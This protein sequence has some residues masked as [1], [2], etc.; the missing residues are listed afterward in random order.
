MNKKTKSVLVVAMLAACLLATIFL[1]PLGVQTLRTAA[2]QTCEGDFDTDGDV[3]GTDLAAF[4]AD[5]GRTNC[6]PGELCYTKTEVDALVADLQSQIDELKDLLAGVTRNVNDITFSGVNV[7]I[8]NGT[9]TTAGPVNGLGNLI[10]GYDEP[11][12]IGSDKTGSHNIVVGRNHNYSSYGGLVAG[13]QNMI[14]ASHASISGGFGNTASANYASVSGGSNNIASGSAASISGGRSNTA[15]GIRASAS[16]GRNNTAS[17]DYAFVGGG[18]GFESVDGNEAFADY[19]AVLGGSQ[20]IAGDP[21]LLDHSIG[22]RATVSGGI[23]NTASGDQSSVSGGGGNTASG[24][25]ASVS[26][27]HINTASGGYA[28]VS[29]GYGN[30][31]GGGRASVSG[32]HSNTASANFSSVSGGYSNTADGERSSVSGGSGRSVSGLYD[33]RAGNLFEGS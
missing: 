24:S 22:E 8:V 12:A 27:G 11:R 1:P 7:R 29:G 6:P 15:S 4:A 28:S 20:N 33:W 5:F 23:G 32:G 25:Y 26:G 2:A 16:G 14:S 31:A 30:T 21:D 10:V 3:D 17:G 9:G 18:G 13:Y 19:S